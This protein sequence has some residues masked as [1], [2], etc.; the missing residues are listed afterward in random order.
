LALSVPLRGLRLLAQRGSTFFIR[1]FCA[2][3][4]KPLPKLGLGATAILFGG[5]A[6]LMLLSTRVVIPVLIS[7][8]GQEPVVLWFVAASICV[9]APM[10]MAG[11]WL[12]FQEKRMGMSTPWKVRL[13]LQT[14]T[15]ADLFWAFGG[16]V[17]VCLLTGICVA[18]LRALGCDAGLHPPFMAMAPLSPGRYWILAAWLPFFLLNIFGEEFVWRGVVLPRQEVVFGK[19]AWL[20]NAVGWWSMHL[21]FPWQVLLTLLPTVIV[22]PAVAQR[23]QNT[24]T[25]IIIHAGLNGMGFLGLAF[26]LA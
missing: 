25:G 2:C 14:I 19:A 3:L 13:R 7:V 17:A 5:A 4:V 20:V 22:V 16:L 12:L 18:I 11:G 26:G 8:C 21:A 10:L 6:L 15:A 24:W 1:R 9:F 23:T